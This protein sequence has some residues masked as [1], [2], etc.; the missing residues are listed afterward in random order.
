MT[1]LPA[2]IRRLREQSEASKATANAHFGAEWLS[3]N[4]ARTLA[5]TCW[6]TA[7]ALYEAPRAAR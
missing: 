3:A 7:H 5:Q 4:E 1:D 2:T 6:D